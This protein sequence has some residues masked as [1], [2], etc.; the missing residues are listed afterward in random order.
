MGYAVVID[1]DELVSIKDQL[2]QVREML[3]ILLNRPAPST[4]ADE[5]LLSIP[6]A[7]KRAGVG[8]KTM[9]K[10]IREGLIN[11][12]KI[13]NNGHYRIHPLEVERYKT[14]RTDTPARKGR[15]A[16]YPMS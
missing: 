10:A 15:H 13:H 6:V 9:K 11:A 4:Q 8:E 7:A 12:T 14:A 1:S 3:D 2:S 5:G 16:K